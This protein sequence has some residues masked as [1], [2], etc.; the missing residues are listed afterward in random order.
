MV[1]VSLA[2]LKT[3]KFVQNP[4]VCAEITG[5][6]FSGSKR[7]TY[8]KYA[9]EVNVCGAQPLRGASSLAGN[10]LQLG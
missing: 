8:V 5:S 6:A 4:G 7:I 9:Y 10:S 1:S 2:K 3:V